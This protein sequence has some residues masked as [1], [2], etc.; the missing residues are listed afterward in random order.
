MN[1]K[2]KNIDNQEDHL[3]KTVSKMKGSILRPRPLGHTSKKRLVSFMLEKFV[4]DSK[5]RRKICF[6]GCSLFFKV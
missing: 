5:N 1:F 6:K 3:G 2:P 4:E